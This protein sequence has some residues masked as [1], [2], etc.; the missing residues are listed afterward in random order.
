MRLRRM[1]LKNVYG[2]QDLDLHFP[3][4]QVT[5][6]VGV[7]GAG[8]STVLDSIAMFLAP[9]AAFLRGAEPRKAPYQLTRDAIHEGEKQ[10]EAALDI[11]DGKHQKTW[12]IVADVQ[13]KEKFFDRKMG[14]WAYQL[15]QT[16]VVDETAPLPVL[17][18]YP[19]VRFY[20]HESFQKKRATIPSH[21]YPQ[22]AAYDNA[23]EIGQRSFEDVVGWFRRQEDL[24][25][26]IRLGGQ[27]EHRDPHLEAVR[28]AVLRFMDTLAPGTFSDLRVARNPLDTSKASLRLQKGSHHLTLDNLSDGERGSL[29]LVAD[30]AQR[31]AAANPGASDP[32]AG[33]G[34]V[35]IDEIELHLHPGWQRKILP[36]LT[37]TF[38]GCQFIVA[39]HSPQVLS[40]VP[41]EQVVLLS[42]FKVVES[43]PYTEGR[44]S[45]AILT[46]LMGVPGRP[47]DAA[48]EV[49]A[50]AH[51][52]DD[53]DF[54]AAKRKL[55]ELEK[56]LGPND[57]DLL[58]L[59]AMLRAMT[60]EP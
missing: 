34:V 46:E 1:R 55:R 53:E 27:P 5:V 42:G 30:L 57:S 38:P 51:L 60:D 25:N 41:R 33:T 45:N 8:K 2:F 58:R 12:R 18:Y 14:N 31:L 32:L 39:T 6:L 13:R 7:N 40:R 4:G 44:D 10:A 21:T 36:A 47:E 26:E 23:F 22:F 16:L 54:A 56:R 24:E 37:K 35:L 19:A 28:Q 29:V 49:D 3:E 52:I 15:H 59:D 43:L 48:A 50:L 11:D 20:L 9:L 17:C